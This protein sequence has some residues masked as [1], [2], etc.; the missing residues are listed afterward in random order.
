MK[1]VLLYA[2]LDA[3]LEARLQAALDVVRLFEGH[4]TC[5]QVTPYDSF[6]MGDPFGGVY[7]LP[8]VIEQVQK[9]AAAHRA[10]IEAR[11]HGEGVAWDWLAFDGAPGQLIVDRARLSDLIVVS[12]PGDDGPNA[13]AAQ[14]IAADVLVHAR[15]PVLAV[16]QA[17]RGLQATGPALVAWDGSIEASHALRLTVPMLLLASAVHIVTVTDGHGEF[18][19]TDAARYLARHGIEAELREWPAEGRRIAGVLNAAA[20]ELAAGYLVMGAY[21]HTRLREAVLGGATRD[22]LQGSKVPLL[23][24]H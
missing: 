3:G 13:Q 6:I 16:P 12:Q 11:L 23:L 21:G 2:N 7:A 4:L 15:A 20:A 10:D 24:A 8:T 5:L 9:T 1:T 22:M 19:A 17:S 18:P 14:A